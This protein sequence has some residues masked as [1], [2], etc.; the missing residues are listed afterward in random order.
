[1][2]EEGY[3]EETVTCDVGT[4]FVRQRYGV[5]W[6]LIGVAGELGG[7]QPDSL[8]RLERA[9]VRQLVRVLESFLLSIHRRP[10]AP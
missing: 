10:K 5:D 2:C 1:M 6:L 8:A 7:T 9:D 4:V 3:R